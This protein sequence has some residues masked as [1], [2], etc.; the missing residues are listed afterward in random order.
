M[1]ITMMMMMMMM[2]FM[3]TNDD[4]NIWMMKN[5]VT[6]T[7]KERPPEFACTTWPGDDDV[8]VCF[9]CSVDDALSGSI[10]M[11]AF[12]CSIDLIGHKYKKFKTFKPLI[13]RKVVYKR[14]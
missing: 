8:S 4:R 12:Y 5:I 3:T 13:D 1:F 7:T 11:N 9:P 10:R 2:I 14:S 6:D